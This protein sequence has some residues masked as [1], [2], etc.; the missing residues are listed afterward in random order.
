MPIGNYGNISGD[1]MFVDPA[2]GDFTLDPSSP[3]SGAAPSGTD[4]GKTGGVF[5]W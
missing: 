4:I 2:N 1:P 3:A 5:G